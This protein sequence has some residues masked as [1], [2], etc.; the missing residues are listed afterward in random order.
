MI[1]P[2]DLGAL[3]PPVGAGATRPAGTSASRGAPAGG[4]AGELD[5]AAKSGEIT[6]SAHAAERL[7]RRGIDMSESDRQRLSDAVR[8]AEGKGG[9]DSLIILGNVALIVNVPNRTVVTA[10]GPDARNERVFTNI[11]SAVIA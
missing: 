9:K 10:M 11:D 1:H 4:F 7:A 8:A 2:I 5:K 3:R 6:F